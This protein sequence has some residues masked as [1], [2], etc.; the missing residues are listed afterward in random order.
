MNPT[1]RINVDELGKIIIE[2]FHTNPTEWIPCS[3]FLTYNIT[4]K[5]SL[6]TEGCI[7]HFFMEVLEPLVVIYPFGIVPIDK[8]GTIKTKLS[9]SIGDVEI[10]VDPEFNMYYFNVPESLE[11]P[12]TITQN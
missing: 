12:L 3:D 9:L 10:K 11:Y 2:S 7:T 6:S 4:S 1:T 8:V 5:C